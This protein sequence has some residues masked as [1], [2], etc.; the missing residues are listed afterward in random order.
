M[1]KM[2]VDD[3]AGAAGR[4]GVGQEQSLLAAQRLP[5]LF[6]DRGHIDS[7]IRSTAA[8]AASMASS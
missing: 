8:S 2:A 7:R 5:H 1:L 6:G 3:L 4:P